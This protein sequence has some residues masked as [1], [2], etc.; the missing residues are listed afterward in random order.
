MVFNFYKNQIKFKATLSSG[1]YSYKNIAS[2]RYFS[3][4]K[5]YNNFNEIN[6]KVINKVLM[7]QQ[8]SI[9][10]QELNKLKKIPG[11]KFDLPFTKETYCSLLK[12]IGKP[13]TRLRKRGVYVFTHKETGNKYVGSSNSLSRRL[14]QY[15]NNLHFNQNNTGLLLPLIQKEGFSAF[16]LE[17]K[18]MPLE[19]NTGYYFLFLEQY[20]LLH[21]DFNLNVQK[22]VN[23]RVKQGTTIYLYNI[24][25][26]VLYYTS[27]SLNQIK[28]DL[29]IHYNTCIKGIKKSDN[30]LN[31]FRITDTPLSKAEKAN[32]NMHQLCDLILEKKAL[33]LKN[34]FSAKKSLS[35]V[36]T[37]EVS[38]KSHKFSSIKE[39]V[40]YLK[41]KNILVNR[42]TI[43]KYL[44]AEKPY[45]GYILYRE[46]KF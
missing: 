44:K 18:V 2:T 38:G 35:V 27:N 45:K 20:Y 13:K 25:G 30:Y 34:T 6:N 39:A 15:F 7:N 23:F 4:I 31:F 10:Q 22:I 33:F 19:L 29:G 12:L 28:D 17:I 32:L 16:N 3:Q 1:F 5:V 8:V 41:S 11:V 46:N 43:S 40:E 14:F 21:S 24:D 42:N 9:T 36:L 37:E 26:T